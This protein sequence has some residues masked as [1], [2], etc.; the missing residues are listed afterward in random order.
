[1]LFRSPKTRESAPRGHL[2]N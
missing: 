2:D 1:V